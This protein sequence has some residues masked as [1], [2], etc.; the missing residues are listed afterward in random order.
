M[1]SNIW[2]QFSW[3]GACNAQAAAANYVTSA[4]GRRVMGVVIPLSEGHQDVPC[5]IRR[6]EINTCC[7]RVDVYAAAMAAC[8]VGF[9]FPYCMSNYQPKARPVLHNFGRRNSL[10][11]MLPQAYVNWRRGLPALADITG[12]HV[13]YCTRIYAV[14]FIATGA[15]WM[16]IP[17]GATNARTQHIFYAST[18]RQVQ[19]HDGAGCSCGRRWEL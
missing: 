13:L 7:G 19:Y 18:R 1:T 17:E 11:R 5:C 14:Q 16:A 2:Q 3:Q 15:A 8:A 9:C 10:N 4:D 12:D 6:Y